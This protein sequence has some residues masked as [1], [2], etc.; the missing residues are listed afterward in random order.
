MIISDVQLEMCS[1]ESLANDIVDSK[2]HNRK[3]EGLIASRQ[4]AFQCGRSPPAAATLIE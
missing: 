4:F 3:Q 2:K 1:F